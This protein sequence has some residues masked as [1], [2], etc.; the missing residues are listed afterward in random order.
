[1]SQSKIKAM[2]VLFF[3]WKSIV[4]HEIVPRGQIVNEQ[5]YQEVLAC[6]RDPVHSK[7]PE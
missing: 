6:L 7:R 4:N 1:M 2:L 3:E 5:L